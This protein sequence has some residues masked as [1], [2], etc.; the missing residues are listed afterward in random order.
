MNQP[1]GKRIHPVYGLTLKQPW[2]WCVS[3]GH[4]TIENRPWKPW[5]TII[6]HPIAIHAGM[7]V[8]RP[9]LPFLD[10]AF[11]LR[12]SV[13]ALVHGAI[14][15][16]ATVEGYVTESPDPWFTGP[17]GWILSGII[18]IPPVPCRGSMGLWRLAPRIHRVVLERYRVFSSSNRV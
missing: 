14:V 7:A 5:S 9:A 18:A 16:V 15:A 12:P 6:G 17:Y 8:D 11:S 10:Q 1:P 2:A 3:A 4:K 13:D